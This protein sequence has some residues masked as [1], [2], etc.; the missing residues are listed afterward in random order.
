MMVMGV[1][2]ERQ[3]L[4]KYHSRCLPLHRGWQLQSLR[5]YSPGTA[6][7]PEYITVSL[8]NNT[9]IIPCSLRGDPSSLK[10]GYVS[11][12]SVSHVTTLSHQAKL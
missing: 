7:R 6:Q 12:Q 11:G 2:G 1:R 9:R 5:A 3:T 10:I 8:R 4:V